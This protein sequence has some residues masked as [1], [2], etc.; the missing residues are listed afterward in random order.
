MD[1]G[2]VRL[3]QPAL[4]AKAGPVLGDPRLAPY[5]LGQQ[6]YAK[7]GQ[8]IDLPERRADRPRR[9]FLEWHLDEVFLKTAP[10][11]RAR[12]E[13]QLWLWRRVPLSHCPRPSVCLSRSLRAL[14]SEITG[15]HACVAAID[16]I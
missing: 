3:E 14:M 1:R 9:D 5:R 8:A 16:C 6:F 13:G 10:G 2:S 7:A 12:P 15:S 4:E 11:A